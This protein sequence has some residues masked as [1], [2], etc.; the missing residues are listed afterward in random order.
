MKFRY[1]APAAVAAALALAVSGCA[2]G[3]GGTPADNTFVYAIGEP[4][5]L[6]PGRQTVAF[7]AVQAL[8]APLVSLD[9]DNSITY[10]QA[11][12]IESDDATTWTVT[13]REGWTFHNGEPV[14]AQS[15]V[16]AWNFTALGTNAWE[17]AGQL[18]NIAG[19]ADVHPAEGDPTAE[20]LSG[21][22]VVDERTFTIELV[23]PDSQFP[24]QLSTGQTGFYPMP[25]A[26][27]DDLE[28][29][30]RQPIGNGPFQL[31]EPWEDN[32]EF[33][34][35]RYEDY[36]GDPAKVDAVTFRPYADSNTAYTDVLAGNADLQFLPPSKTTSAPG[37]FG[38]RLYSFDAPGIDYLGFPLWDERYTKEVRQAISMSI[39]R[40]AVNDAIYG[41]LYEPATALTPP[42]M[43]G[44][45]EGVCGEF[46]EF[47]AAAAKELFDSQGFTGSIDI[48]YPGGIGLDELFEAYANQIRQNL[49]HDDVVTKPS[50]DWA[51]YFQT[52]TDK[53][54][55][56]PH[57]GHW[58]ALYQSQQN[59][60]R[61]LFTAAGGCAACTGYYNDPEVD[62][63]LAEADA[64][65]TPE[66]ASELYAAVQERVI[67]DFPIVPT[68]FDTYSYV[69]SDKIAVLPD[70]AGSPVAYRIELK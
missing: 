39:D 52:V 4:D 10:V 34:A 19:Y 8:F 1:L 32:T 5:H 25:E 23:G 56:G 12:S 45:P 16:D 46:C 30:D 65:A 51:S 41:G 6:T 2:G 22:A 67:E 70:E 57:F 14:T 63:L 7:E 64:A 24:L 69:T 29:Y 68:F 54:V 20:T 44:T 13:L 9:D 48:V 53:T 35:E 40:D 38:D 58:G 60:L 26:A 21:L 17:N 43:T 50:T 47:D 66:E 28:A 31:T 59:T 62:A 18:V 61:A 11:E 3:G 33:T 49:G 42:A 36:G 27:Y 55:T 37:D 15:Y